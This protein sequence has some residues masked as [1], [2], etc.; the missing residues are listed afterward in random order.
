MRL[1]FHQYGRRQTSQ[2]KSMRFL[3]VAD[4][5]FNCDIPFQQYA[6]L[7]EK[8][9][10]HSF[11]ISADMSVADRPNSLVIVCHYSAHTSS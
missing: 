2:I 1:T 6:S 7:G 5:D 4:T 10:G 3:N 8:D 11:E 9:H